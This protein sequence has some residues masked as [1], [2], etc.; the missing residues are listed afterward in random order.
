[1][2]RVFFNTRRNVVDLTTTYQV[3]ASDSGNLFVIDQ[4]SSFVIT[5]P[6]M[7]AIETGWNC[8]FIIGTADANA[9]TIIN[10]DADGN[11]DTIVGGIAGA[12]GGAGTS[13]ETAVDTITFIS[14]AKLGDTCNIVSN[15]TN[16]FVSGF[17]NDVAHITVD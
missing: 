15:G 9:V 12:D 16:Y 11:E 3:L 6:L 14:G 2:G 7:S 4:S 1:M 10:N 17:G 8:Q 13:S 5:L